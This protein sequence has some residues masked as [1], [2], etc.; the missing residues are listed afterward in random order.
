MCPCGLFPAVRADNHT[1]VRVFE[2]FLIFTHS[3]P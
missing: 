2:S 1:I 3:G